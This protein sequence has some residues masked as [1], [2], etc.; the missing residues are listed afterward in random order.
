MTER[1]RERGGGREGRTK[2]E[3]SRQIDSESE[4]S[5]HGLALVHSLGR[6]T[7]AKLS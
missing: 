6:G 3:T 7:H 4:R 1:D 5:I 2:I